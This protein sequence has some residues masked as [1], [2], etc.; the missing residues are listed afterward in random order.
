MR[1]HWAFWL[2]SIECVF[3]HQF[4]PIC[5]TISVFCKLHQHQHSSAC[6]IGQHEVMICCHCPV[7]LRKKRCCSTILEYFQDLCKQC[8][9]SCI[10]CFEDQRPFVPISLFSCGHCGFVQCDEFGLCLRSFFQV[11]Y[12]SNSYCFFFQLCQS[13]QEISR[14]VFVHG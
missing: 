14:R 2:C 10:V 5:L 7:Q 9:S 3:S 8:I 11:H 6:Q 13:L 4:L 12:G 1:F